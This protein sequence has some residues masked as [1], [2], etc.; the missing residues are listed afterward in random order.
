MNMK[1]LNV[2]LDQ[3]RYEA[4]ERQAKQ[5]RKTCAKVAEDL[6]S[7]GLARRDAA[8]RR[9]KLAADYRAGYADARALLSD[10]ELPQ[11]E[12]LDDEGA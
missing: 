7:E 11:S 12:L 10:C 5:T 4:L 6:L 8:I 1:R 2:T 3:E 9:K